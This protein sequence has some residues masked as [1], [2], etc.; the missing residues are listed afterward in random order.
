MRHLKWTIRTLLTAFI[1]YFVL[2][3]GY[4]LFAAAEEYSFQKPSLGYA[5]VKYWYHFSMNSYFNDKIERM[6]EMDMD[7][8]NYAPPPDGEN[9]TDKKYENNVSTYCVA[10]GALDMY[11]AYSKTLDEVK[12]IIGPFEFSGKL[13]LAQ[14]SLS[15]IFNVAGRRDDAVETEKVEAL[16]L[17]ELTVSAYNELR[18]AYPM[19]KKYEA[20]IVDLTRYRDFLSDVRSRSEWLPSKYIDATSRKGCK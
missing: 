12:A 7:D 10:M 13:P 19:H 5:A 8:P 2:W 3:G 20:L 4:S 15:D 18:L 1:T 9:C 6:L 16:K 11:L 14:V 17:M